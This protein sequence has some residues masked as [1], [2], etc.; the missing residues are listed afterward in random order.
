M[1]AN[2]SQATMLIDKINGV[3]GQQELLKAKKEEY[4]NRVKEHNET[5]NLLNKGISDMKTALGVL[6]TVKDMNTAKTYAFI[7]HNLNLALDKVFTG[8]VRK[9]HLVEGALNQK[10]PELRLELTTEN[11]IKRSLKADSGHGMRQIVSL[12]CTLCLIC[13]SGT[14]KFLVLD[15][16]LTGLSTESK[17]AVDEILWA[18]AD[19][20][21]QFIIA[22]HGFIAKGS[23]VYE[24]EF[25]NGISKCTNDYVAEQG[26]YSDKNAEVNNSL[27][28]MPTES[29]D[30]TTDE[31]SQYTYIE[32]TSEQIAFSS[33]QYAI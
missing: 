5:I 16:V 27:R 13:I 33:T 22:E 31:I 2:V 32:P 10:Y 23:H 8:K 3:L 28:E 19:I 25:N 6:N 24:L 18:F 14:R 26:F 1:N 9:I 4:E 29:L 21:F 17:Q 11:G 15:E 30:G 12:L 7:E 20:G